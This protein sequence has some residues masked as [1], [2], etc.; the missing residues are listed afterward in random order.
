[1]ANENLWGKSNCQLLNGS[2]CTA[3]C[4]V[5][6]IPE[7]NK[8]PATDCQHQTQDGC[9]IFGKRERPTRCSQFH[10]RIY[11]DGKHPELTLQAALVATRALELR[12]ITQTQYG[13]I[14]EKIT[15]ANNK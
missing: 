15:K 7:L 10:C 14:L 9:R 3:C 1:M 6:D 11:L 4:H 13:S 2:R 12:Q 5:L 8:P